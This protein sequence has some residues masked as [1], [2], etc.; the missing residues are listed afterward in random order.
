MTENQTFI[1]ESLA[2]QLRT[3]MLSMD[4]IKENVLEEIE[5]NEFS[6]Q[7]PETWVDEQLKNEFNKLV[8]ETENWKKPTDT[9]RLIEAFNS[10]VESNIIA[11]HIAGYTTSEGEYEVIEVERE[12]RANGS[13]SIGYCFYHEQDLLRVINNQ[14]SSLYIAFQKVDNSEDKVTIELGQKIVNILKEH[15]FQVEWDGTANTKIALN[16]FKWQYRYNEDN[17]DLLDYNSIVDQML[18]L[19]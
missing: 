11:L 7:I 6:E 18:L 13:G 4:E 5:D 17:R 3:G 1:Y 9:E 19:K 2:A 8:I 16:N 10:L 12:L 14:N 15:Q